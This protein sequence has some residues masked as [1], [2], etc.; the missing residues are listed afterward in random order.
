M[1][2]K[3]ALQIILAISA[4][5][6]AFSGSLVYREACSLSTGGCSVTGGNRMFGIPVCVYGLVMYLLVASFA[7]LGLRGA[8]KGER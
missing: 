7:L 8:V 1:S 5:G 4:I 6:I 2:A 3:R